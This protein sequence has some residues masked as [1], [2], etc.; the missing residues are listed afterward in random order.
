MFV[1]YLSE[2]VGNCKEG[3]CP[4]VSV[5]SLSSFHTFI[6][7]A[8]IASSTYLAA[9]TRNSHHWTSHIISIPSF[10]VFTCTF[11]TG[12]DTAQQLCRAHQPLFRLSACESCEC[13]PETS[14][15]L[16]LE[17][18]CTSPP[19]SLTRPRAWS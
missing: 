17:Y 15:S 12:V 2:G 11:G 9:I 18:C 19:P 6:S 16:T 13:C 5:T 7:T 14:L 1:L 4:F 3:H 10:F 8:S